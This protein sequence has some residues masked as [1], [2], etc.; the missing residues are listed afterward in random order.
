LTLQV[1]FI[2]ILYDN[3]LIL[4][5]N[6]YSFASCFFFSF[7]AGFLPVSAS[8]SSLSTVASASVASACSSY[9]VASTRWAAAIPRRRWAGVLRTFPLEAEVEGTIRELFKPVYLDAVAG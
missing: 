4:P 1:I 3:Q 5:V 2:F 6:I 9:S 7:T 8:I